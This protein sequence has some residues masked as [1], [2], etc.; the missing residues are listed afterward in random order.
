MGA[1]VQWQQQRATWIELKPTENK[2]ENCNES[3]KQIFKENT[4]G[5]V[6]VLIIFVNYGE[7]PT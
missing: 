2:N 6:W 3:D 7:K 4:P 1:V 5:R